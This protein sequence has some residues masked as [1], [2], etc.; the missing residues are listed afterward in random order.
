MQIYFVILLK[1][2][3]GGGLAI[4][5]KAMFSPKLLFDIVISD[6]FECV[7]ILTSK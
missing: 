7:Q 3:W 6:Y 5:P 4:V 1:N 2:I